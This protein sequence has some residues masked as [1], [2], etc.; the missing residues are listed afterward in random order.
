MVRPPEDRSASTTEPRAT[1]SAA[2]VR[3]IVKT[4]LRLWFAGIWT[5][6]C[7]AVMALAAFGPPG[8]DMD[9]D[10][11]HT[12]VSPSSLPVM[13]TGTLIAPVPVRWPKSSD[14][15]ATRGNAGGRATARAAVKCIGPSRWWDGAVMA[16]SVAERS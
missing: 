11:R 3:D 13:V 9:E 10:F 7:P 1:P 12:C 16:E 4:S 2:V 15:G 5:H 8:R 6:P 14:V